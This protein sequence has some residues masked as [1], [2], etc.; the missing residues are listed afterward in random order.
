MESCEIYLNF[1]LAFKDESVHHMTFDKIPLQNIF[2][3][4]RKFILSTV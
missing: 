1:Y 2:V 4:V 3:S